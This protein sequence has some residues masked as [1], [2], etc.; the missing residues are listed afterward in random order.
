MEWPANA[1]AIPV[2]LTP[3]S[4]QVTFAECN[5]QISTGENDDILAE[6]DGVNSGVHW[7]GWDSNYSG[8][9]SNTQS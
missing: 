6:L 8:I 7:T 2:T 9:A 3:S 5:V 1:N 4:N